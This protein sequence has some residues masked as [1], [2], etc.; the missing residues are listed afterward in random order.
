MAVPFEE[1]LRIVKRVLEHGEGKS[2]V[3][4]TEGY[5]RV[6][7]RTWVSQYLAYGETGLVKKKWAP[8]YSQ[9]TKDEFLASVEVEGLTVTQASKK[10]G[11]PKQT[12]YDW[13][14]ERDHALPP[15]QK[16][17][18]RMQK[19]KLAQQELQIL[20]RENQSKRTINPGSLSF[21]TSL[22]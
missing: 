9:K 22:C 11:I 10:F 2:H 19:A 20:R 4:F 3:A 6:A 21:A 12:F 15:E 16:R 5:S 13:R 1:R 7:I 18:K 8:K 17:E 14:N